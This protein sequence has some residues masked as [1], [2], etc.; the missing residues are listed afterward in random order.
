M[1]DLRNGK[2]VNMAADEVAEIEGMRERARQEVENREPSEMDVLVSA[3]KARGVIDDA[4][5]V[6]ARASRKAKK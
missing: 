6:A 1:K 4:D 2:I 5:L 3:L